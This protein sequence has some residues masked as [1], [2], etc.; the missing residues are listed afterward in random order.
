MKKQK[1]I[2][3]L[4]ALCMMVLPMFCIHT[5][6]F[7]VSKSGLSNFTKKIAY[8]S[9]DDVKSGDWY[10][11]N[12]KSV[13]EYGIMRGK[14]DIVFDADGNISIAETIAIAA[15]IHS[16]YHT[17]R[18]DFKE[19]QTWY[20]VYV[21]Y[22]LK[23]SLITSEYPEYTVAVTRVEFAKI[24]V[25]ALPEKEFEQIN[26]VDDDIIP[27][28]KLSDDY[29]RAVYT[30]YRAG[31]ITGSNESGVFRPDTNIKRCEAAAVVTR[32]LDVSLRKTV[33]YTWDRDYKEEYRKLLTSIINVFGEP[34]YDSFTLVYI[35]GDD[36]PELVAT[37]SSYHNGYLWQNTDIYSMFYYGVDLYDT[38]FSSH[39]Y[40]MKYIPYKNC[41]YCVSDTMLSVRQLRVDF[42]ET[43]Y[44]KIESVTDLRDFGTEY[45]VDGSSATKEEYESAY[46]KYAEDAEAVPLDFAQYP[47]HEYTFNTV[48]QSGTAEDEAQEHALSAEAMQDM[49]A[50]I[51]EY[52][53]DFAEK[54][55]SELSEDSGVKFGVLNIFGTE[56]P[57]LL[58]AKPLNQYGLYSIEIFA[59]DGKFASCGTIEGNN[60]QC[61]YSGDTLTSYTDFGSADGSTTNVKLRCYGYD[62]KMINLIETYDY[63]LKYTRE[64][65]SVAPIGMSKTYTVTSAD[66]EKQETLSREDFYSRIDGIN[67]GCQVI[68][69]DLTKENI[70]EVVNEPAGYRAGVKNRTF[71][72]KFDIEAEEEPAVYESQKTIY[73]D[74]I[75][76]KY[77]DI[78]NVEIANGY[79]EHAGFGINNFG[80]AV[81]WTILIEFNDSLE[82]IDDVYSS[83][84]E[85]VTCINDKT[86]VGEEYDDYGWQSVLQGN[87]HWHSY[88]NYQQKNFV[89]IK[90]PDNPE[91]AGEQYLV[92]NGVKIAFQLEYLGDYKTGM[93]WDI[94]NINV[95]MNEGQ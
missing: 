36:I 88:T 87:T 68:F 94:Y 89:G 65:G 39:R 53:S 58:I 86:Y 13:Y 3:A 41:I 33:K 24:L 40:T 23:N 32:M 85:T 20:S 16:I 8:S 12:V 28:V 5:A 48:L 92:I 54:L 31:I 42:S 64:L 78:V 63:T 34:Y 47:V 51:T 21:D 50:Y 69:Y 37:E 19:S 77:F 62:G 30:L 38:L 72:E 91:I 10:Y 75:A 6:A 67:A 80:Q 71:F 76:H 57:Q 70:S 17:G 9:F 79:N 81:K 11:K 29:G 27:D 52:S 60:L 46:N 59:Y 14:S 18:D 26:I 22:A 66:T 93:G 44:T 25:N 7:G 74:D 55:Y 61:S 56:Y 45:R 82:T 83:W 1:L 2:S 43:D 15:R 49:Y 35:D 90:L 73:I 95:S 84:D 4:T